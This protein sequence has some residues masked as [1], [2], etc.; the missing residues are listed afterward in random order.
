MAG[1]A[2]LTMA[3]GGHFTSSIN[4][5]MDAPGELSP[6]PYGDNW[7]DTKKSLIDFAD[8]HSLENAHRSKRE[9]EFWDSLK[10]VI[11][12]NVKSNEKEAEGLNKVK[13]LFKKL[14]AKRRAS[15]QAEDEKNKLPQMSPAKSISPKGKRMSDISE[16]TSDDQ[17]MT[18][19]SSD[20]SPTKK[21]SFGPLSN[22]K[23]YIEKAAHNVA[24]GSGKNILSHSIH[25]GPTM[26]KDEYEEAAKKNAHNM[27]EYLEGQRNSRVSNPFLEKVRAKA[28]MAKKRQRQ[29]HAK[30]INPKSPRKI[31]WDLLCGALIIYSVVVTPWRISFE[32][33]PAFLSFSFF[34]EIFIDVTFLMDM[35]FSFFTGHF[36]PEGRF[37][38]DRRIIA[39]KYVTSWFAIDFLS[40]FPFDR[41]LPLLAPDLFT[42]ESSLRMIKLIRTLRLFRLLKLL[43]ILKLSSKLGNT[44]GRDISE[45]IPPAMTRLI[46]LLFKIMFIAH[47]LACF[48]FLSNE[49]IA[50]KDPMIQEEDETI[51]ENCGSHT[52]TSQYIAS[53]YWTIA[54]MMAVGYGDISAETNSERAYAIVT[55][56][57]G[58]VAF[59]FIIATVTIIIETVDPEATAKKLKKDE[60]RDY[61]NERRYSKD[62]QKRAKQHFN[63]YQSRMSTFPEMRVVSELSHTLKEVVLYESRNDTIPAIKMFRSHVSDQF[64]TDCVLRLKPM[65]MSYHQGFGSPGDISEEVY[66]VTKGRIEG[67]HMVPQK[68]EGGESGGFSGKPKEKKSGGSESEKEGEGVL[69]DAVLATVVSDG[70]ELELAN[71][72]HEKPMNLRYRAASVTDVLWLDHESLINLTSSYHRSAATL[73]AR[74]FKY[75]QLLAAVFNSEVKNLTEGIF[76]HNKILKNDQIVRYSDVKESV[77]KSM[78]PGGNKSFGERKRRDTSTNKG[79]KIEKEMSLARRL[80]TKTI[81]SGS[82]NNDEEEEQTVLLRTWVWDPATDELC[83]KEETEEDLWKRMLINPNSGSKLKWDIFVGVLIIVSVI[84]VPFRLGFDIQATVTWDTY[85][86]TTDF[87]FLLDIFIN[88]RTCFL[89]DH[90]V[91]H[92]ASTIISEHYLRGWFTVDF[93]STIPLDRLMASLL[94]SSTGLKGLKMIRIV[95]LVRLA[96][97][98]KLL[99]QQSENSSEDFIP[100][101]AT[102]QKVLKLLATLFFIGHLFGCFFSYIS[103]DNVAEYG[104]LVN[105]TH[106]G[107][108]GD[109]A[110][111]LDYN[112]DVPYNG[113]SSWWVKVNV[114]GDDIGSRYLVALYWAFTTM[115][116]V[117]Y[118]DVTPATDGE[119]IYASLIM[120]MGATVFGYIVGSVSGLASNPH[121]ALARENERISTLTNY[122]EEQNIKPA[123]R[124]MARE[125]LSFNRA[126]IS[127]F[128]ESRIL[129]S[130]PINIRREMILETHADTIE[131]ISLFSDDVSLITN[132][133]HYLK[134]S[135]FSAG[136]F[137]YRT[138]DE[139]VKGIMFLL[140]GIA[141]EV[142]DEEWVDIGKR[143]RGD[144][145]PIIGKLYSQ[146]KLDKKKT[147]A[148]GKTAEELEKEKEEEEKKKKEHGKGLHRNII[149]AGKCFGYQCFVTK[150]RDR[151]PM[152]YRAFSDCSIMVLS[153]IALKA[154]IERHPVLRD[155]LSDSLR[156]SIVRQ[157]ASDDVLSKQVHK[158]QKK[159]SLFHALQ[160][161][162]MKGV[163]TGDLARALQKDATVQQIE[164]EREKSEASGLKVTASSPKGPSVVVGK[165]GKGELTL[166]VEELDH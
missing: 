92:T 111:E 91:L 110:W 148:G 6:Q 53:F 165:E 42:D 135:F 87:F 99:R 33:D 100:M 19:Q 37:I 69:F 76:M 109:G 13:T 142:P 29:K 129:S 107:I 26:P 80:S 138:S 85:D 34:F 132:V 54:T 114:D 43:R 163:K 144:N 70:Y 159:N 125:Q 21:R 44:A 152:A 164:V 153:E 157:T 166:E 24:H 9:H 30:V 115:T 103:L 46:K 131:K 7:S 12:K 139:G 22:A 101:D 61:L 147:G 55:Q 124:R 74:A 63:Y 96:K 35:V 102:L 77:L 51:W 98:I 58:A 28:A 134:P 25:L 158:L 122:L 56:V 48:W 52:L 65:L 64:I 146:G 59:G 39:K 133:L 60:L 75:E 67:L 62:L 83:E 72:L 94:P 126:F 112:P 95:R 113:A 162:L 88:F 143:D 2:T 50:I 136:Q 154:I 119:R 47:L 68:L 155:K 89:D 81:S 3:A 78:R 20:E 150:D 41:V 15:R 156:M 82:L 149:E 105:G 141:E 11:D 17:A 117:G 57:I 104:D 120:I 40:T 90:Q 84:M 49:C 18:P 8:P 93:L 97:L 108:E 118:G 160:T 161:N 145:V 71:C 79:K 5:D 36:T 151:K 123:L 16:T 31:Y 106:M 128:D 121:G 130:F 127:V 140:D 27:D 14:G 86:W 45:I 10:L 38:A 66:F 23:V 1:R 116:T 73:H 32:Q 4:R 137:I